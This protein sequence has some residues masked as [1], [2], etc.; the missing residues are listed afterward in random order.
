MLLCISDTKLQE[1]TTKG[2]VLDGD[3]QFRNADCGLRI[4]RTGAPCGSGQRVLD[5]IDLEE[6]QEFLGRVQIAGYT[7]LYC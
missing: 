2:K 4:R 5:G 3:I 6:V 1:I 7:G